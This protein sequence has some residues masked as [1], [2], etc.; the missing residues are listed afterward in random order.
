MFHNYIPSLSPD[1]RKPNL[2]MSARRRISVGEWFN[3]LILCPDSGMQYDLLLT[4]KICGQQWEFANFD[5]AFC[6]QNQMLT[7]VI[8]ALNALHPFFVFI[9]SESNAISRGKLRYG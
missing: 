3:S 7:L 5:N 9:I 1:H 2:S 8:G 6:A 4:A